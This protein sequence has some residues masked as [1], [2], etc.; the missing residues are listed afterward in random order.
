[1]QDKDKF[2]AE[3]EKYFDKLVEYDETGIDNSIELYEKIHHIYMETDDEKVAEYMAKSL[4]NISFY[5]LSLG[6]EVDS[7][8]F[9][10]KLDEL[11]L[12]HTKNQVIIWNMAYC[13]ANIIREVSEHDMPKALN[14]F[15]NLE[16]WQKKYPENEDIAD[17]LGDACYNLMIDI[18]DSDKE[19]MYL[20]TMKLNE[21]QYNYPDNEMLVQHFMYASYNYINF[22]SEDDI[23]DSLELFYMMKKVS[24]KY[25]DN[26]I[27]VYESVKAASRLIGLYRQFDI[28]MALKLFD[29]IDEYSKKHSDDED[30]AYFTVLKAY[31]LIVELKDSDTFTFNE[32]IDCLPKIHDFKE[33]KSSVIKGLKIAKVFRNKEGH[34]VT[35]WHDYNPEN[36][37]DSSGSSSSEVVSGLKSFVS[38][39]IAFLALHAVGFVPVKL[40][41]SALSSVTLIFFSASLPLFTTTYFQFT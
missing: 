39:S 41:A 7:F 24:D 15:K 22:F 33:E 36:Y 12:M 20:L 6:R 40:P 35:L 2:I 10:E 32:V 34:S 9:M 23:S 29:I 37:A 5:L 30:I 13:Y 4:F 8:S 16:S 11:A 26:H 18:K 31:N 38:H 28:K 19:K 1:M 25:I 21:L 17:R 3:A 14:L 27:L